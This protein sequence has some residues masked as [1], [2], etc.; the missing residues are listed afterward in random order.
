MGVSRVPF[1]AVNQAGTFTRQQAYDEGWTPRQV[2]RRVEA[3]RWTAITRSVLCETA[4]AVG[5]WQL[6]LRRRC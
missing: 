5:P 1:E 3:G 4:T 2:R 6:A